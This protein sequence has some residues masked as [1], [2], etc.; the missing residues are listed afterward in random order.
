M[1]NRYFLAMRMLRIGQEK[2]SQKCKINDLEEKSDIFSYW[3][4]K[5]IWKSGKSRQNVIRVY[6]L[7]DGKTHFL[8]L[9]KKTKHF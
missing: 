2:I 3:T 7:W 1:R 4:D 5:K 9:E 8:F 6:C